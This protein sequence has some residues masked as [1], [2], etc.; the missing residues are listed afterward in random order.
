V[1]GVQ[2]CALPIC[3]FYYRNGLTTLNYIEILISYLADSFKKTVCLELFWKQALFVA[4]VP[5][6]STI[7]RPKH[8]STTQY[9]KIKV[10]V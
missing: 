3:W 6:I 10:K 7:A 4:V 1:T 9:G 8:G 5:E 2:T